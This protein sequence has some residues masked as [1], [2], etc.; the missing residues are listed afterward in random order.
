MTHLRVEFFDGSSDAIIPIIEG[1]ITNGFA[2]E[3]HA[4]V[5]V[6]RDDWSEDVNP[7]LDK[8]N[9]EFYIE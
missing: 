2:T 8:I 9:D 7:T 6:F 1:S 3:S 4:T 5:R